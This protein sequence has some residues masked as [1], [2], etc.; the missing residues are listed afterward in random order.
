MTRGI[1]RGT[2]KH[3]AAKKTSGPTQ[4]ESDRKRKQR[5][6]R[7]SDAELELLDRAAKELGAK[8]RSDAIVL[9]ATERLYRK[10]SD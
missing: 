8:S 3:M 1:P 2:V 5:L 9:L 6:M 10:S 4:A 7:L